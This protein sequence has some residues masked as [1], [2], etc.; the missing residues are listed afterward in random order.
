MAEAKAFAK[1]RGWR[2]LEV[3]TPPLPQFDKSLAFYERERFYISGEL[4]FNRTNTA[5]IA[6]QNQTLKTH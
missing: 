1:A 4:R 3:T 5:P 6:P 2:S